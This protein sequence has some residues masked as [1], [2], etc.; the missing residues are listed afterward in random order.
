MHAMRAGRRE[1]AVCVKAA[2][3]LVHL[4]RDQEFGIH[5]VLSIYIEM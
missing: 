3:S 2:L 5:Y 1:F 4:A